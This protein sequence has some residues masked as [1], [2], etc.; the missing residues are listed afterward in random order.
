M[1]KPLTLLNQD[2][3]QAYRLHSITQ[4]PA[5]F[6]LTDLD[7]ELLQTIM[8]TNTST[9]QKVD[10]F[11]NILHRYKNILEQYQ[12]SNTQPQVS[13][14]PPPPPPIPI[15]AAKQEPIKTPFKQTIPAKPLQ[16]TPKSKAIIDLH[17][18][19]DERDTSFNSKP[20]NIVVADREIPDKIFNSVMEAFKKQK[21]PVFSTSQQKLIQSIYDVAKTHPNFLN[22]IN[23]LPGLGHYVRSKTIMTTRTEKSSPLDAKRNIQADDDDDEYED[24]E[25]DV[26]QNTDT[27]DNDQ[28]DPNIT[29]REST[30]S[31][32]LPKPKKLKKVQKPSKRGAGGFVHLKRWQKHMKK[33]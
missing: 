12:D 25:T 7:K 26:P 13:A 8:S 18:I 33:K 5:A 29:F 15:S 11:H 24:I 17:K 22:V 14:P 32:P 10:K 3:A 31:T 4:P 1:A 23:N 30:S 16:R 20:G 6:E 19:L 28:L 2:I 27:F 21:N 9:R